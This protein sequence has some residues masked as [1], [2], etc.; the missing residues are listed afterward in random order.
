MELNDDLLNLLNDPFLF[1]QVFGL[2]TDVIK[3]VAW[4]ARRWKEVRDRRRS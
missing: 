4:L 2:A 1:I 3:A